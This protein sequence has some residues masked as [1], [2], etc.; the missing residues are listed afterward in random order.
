MFECR[1]IKEKIE[2]P[3][4]QHIN[5]INDENVYHQ[6][7]QFLDE[8]CKLKEIDSKKTIREN[9]QKPQDKYKSK[10]I[11]KNGEIKLLIKIPR[12]RYR[13]KNTKGLKVTLL[14]KR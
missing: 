3:K 1:K 6:L 14:R 7:G 4:I 2:V 11:S 10:N 13:V 8:V 12:I 9:L 5:D